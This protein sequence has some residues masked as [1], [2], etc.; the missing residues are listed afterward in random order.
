M[1]VHNNT[2]TAEP[3]NIKRIK[4]TTQQLMKTEDANVIEKLTS[5]LSTI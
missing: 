3:L 2:P 4:T 5:I 1:R